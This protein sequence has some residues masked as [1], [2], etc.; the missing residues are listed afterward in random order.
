[1]SGQNQTAIYT[2]QDG[3]TTHVGSGGKIV[4]ESGG[5]LEVQAGATQS[6][7]GSV[8]V[9]ADQTFSGTD[10]FSGTVDVTG[11]QKQMG[12]DVSDDRTYRHSAN[13]SMAQINAGFDLLALVTG[14]KFKVVGYYFR[15]NGGSL[16]GATD[17]RLSDTAGSPVDIVTIAAAAATSGA[18]VHHG[19]T[20]ANVTK[21]AGWLAQLTVSKGV[22]IRKTGSSGTT[23]VSVDVMIDY[24]LAA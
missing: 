22:Q 13:V 4:V 12:K 8:D 17:I 7:L 3:A 19:A 5:T 21:G 23:L 24:Q 15:F 6:L 14:K 10:T 11:T 18:E 9:T 20:I 16:G 1:M 2:E